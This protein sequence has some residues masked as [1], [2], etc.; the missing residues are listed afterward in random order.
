MATKLL[1]ELSI[2]YSIASSKRA[3]LVIPNLFSSFVV[4]SCFSA[5]CFDRSELRYNICADLSIVHESLRFSKETI[6]RVR[7]APYSAY[8]VLFDV[9]LITLSPGLI[10]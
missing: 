9:K 8:V 7:I 3:Q 4:I 10:E 1:A 5:F 6:Q 2:N